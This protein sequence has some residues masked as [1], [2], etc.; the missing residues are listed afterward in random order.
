MI[1][2]ARIVL[3]GTTEQN[4]V[5]V[6]PVDEEGNFDITVSDGQYIAFG[7]GDG[8]YS[9]PVVINSGPN[10]TR[11]DMVAKELD[12]ERIVAFGFVSSSD[13]NLP[14]PGAVLVTLEES[15]STDAA[16]FYFIPGIDPESSDIE[17][18]ADG[19]VVYD[20]RINTAEESGIYH[21][22]FSLVAQSG[23]TTGSISGI[24]FE[25]LDSSGDYDPAEDIQLGGTM[26]ALN[27]N[28]YT[29]N[30]NG[31]YAFNNVPIGDY[32]LTVSRTGYLA[33]EFQIDLEA[34]DPVIELDIALIP[35]LANRV[36]VTGHLVDPEGDPVTGS[37]VVLSNPLIG[38]FSVDGDALGA[39]RFTEIPPAEY[40]L[41][42]IPDPALISLA[43]ASTY[44]E[45]PSGTTLFEVGTISVP[46][47]NSGGIFGHAYLEFDNSEGN[48]RV[49]FGAGTVVT[50]V[51]MDEPFEGF[52][53][54]TNTS[55][56][57]YFALQGLPIGRYVL[58]AYNCQ[59]IVL[60]E[61]DAGN[62]GYVISQ[63]SIRFCWQIENVTVTPLQA[64]RIN[65][66]LDTPDFEWAP[67]NF[68]YTGTPENER[69]HV[70]SDEF[71]P[72]E[73]L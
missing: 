48:E 25:D 29:T 40:T 10:G 44:I 63:P 73:G 49:L 34:A 35:D 55:P 2:E 15:F 14:V 67:D 21:Q 68:W 30:W 22:N 23:S 65:M 20:G 11:V 53:R 9:E 17:I 64:T 62:Q 8:Y 52:T 58:T 43:R 33:R 60:V 50:A 51:K 19:F 31:E 32:T 47:N 16:G 61:D 36:V 1:P 3:L 54:T 7:L 70:C 38:T 42:V 24:V 6:F 72:C 39:F 37:T 71:D 5:G 45:V 46:F 59:G 66:T 28:V 18:M 12:P 57:A 41:T 27:G 26:L 13:N 4:L 56:T 69:G